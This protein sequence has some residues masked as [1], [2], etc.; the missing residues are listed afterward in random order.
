MKFVKRLLLSLFI[1]L[2]LMGILLFVTQ[3]GA[4]ADT[5][6]VTPE[7][8]D[9]GAC[10]QEIESVWQSGHHAQASTNEAFTSAWAAQGQP[11]ACLECHAP[12]YDA[13]SASGA[14]SGVTCQTCHGPVLED[15]P[16]QN[17]QVDTSGQLCA[18]CHSQPITEGVAGSGAHDQVGMPCT[19]CHNPHATDFQTPPGAPAGALQNPSLLCEN[20]HKDVAAEA[21]HSRHAAANVGC[22]DCHMGVRPLDANNPHAAP[23]HTARASLET[24]N[25]CH[26]TQMH[27][28]TG[29]AQAVWP[30]GQ[31]A[32]PETLRA[33]FLASSPTPVSPLGY[34]II[35]LLIGLACGFALAPLFQRSSKR[36][37]DK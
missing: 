31:P 35:S 28:S 21:Q 2:P 25:A 12:G 26:S 18:K 9:C 23:D 10:H 8:S 11:G 37:G 24:C 7:P 4:Q 6:Q 33:S 29:S 16:K 27:A 17:M 3:T 34:V 15:H 20:C 14:E 1:A 36:R 30:T 19:S 5:A 22:V 13:E 32:T